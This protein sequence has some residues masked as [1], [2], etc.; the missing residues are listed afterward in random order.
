[1]ALTVRNVTVD[2][3][4]EL[5]N[6]RHMPYTEKCPR[7]VDTP[8]PDE[9]IDELEPLS[10]A[11]RRT[12]LH[13]Y[14]CSSIFFKGKQGVE[15]FVILNNS[16]EAERYKDWLFKTAKKLPK[17]TGL[18]WIKWGT[19]D[20]EPRLLVEYPRES[21]EEACEE[22]SSREPETAEE[23]EKLA[24]ELIE[25]QELAKYPDIQFSSCSVVLVD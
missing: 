10:R 5:P 20:S 8:L 2:E 22:V 3:L 12:R 4:L 11:E 14:A 15:S 24:L 9:L 13:E 17:K 21:F 23:T 19:P 7:C 6:G 1:M 18:M 25:K 16:R